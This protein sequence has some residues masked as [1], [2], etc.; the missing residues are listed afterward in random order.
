MQDVFSGIIDLKRD[1]GDPLHI[2]LSAQIKQA[3]LSGA[4]PAQSRIPSSRLLAAKL[5]ISRNTVMA[6]LEQLKAEGYLE[7]RPGAAI[8]V[9]GIARPDLQSAPGRREPVNFGHKFAQ[10]WDEPLRKFHPAPYSEPQPFQ[11]GIPDLSSFPHELWSKMLRRAARQPFQPAAGYAHMSGVARFRE[12]LCQHLI[13]LRGV[14]AEPEQIIVTSSARGALSLIASALLNPGEVAWIE[15]PG[16]RSAKAIFMAAGAELHPVP[17][18]AQGIDVRSVSAANAQRLRLIYTTPSHQYPTG[19]VMSLPRRLELLDLAARSGAY[20]LEDDYDSEFQYRGRPIAALQ[21]LDRTGCVLY[22]G[23]FAKS[24]LPALRVGFIIVPKVLAA[25]FEMIHRHTG[26]F[27]PPV[28]QL[29][30]AD[31]IESGHYRAHVRKMKSIYAARL[32]A[33]A[34]AITQISGG[35]LCVQVPDG[36]LQTVVTSRIAMDDAMLAVHLA[37]SGIQCQPLRDF[38][39]RLPMRGIMAY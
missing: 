38:H 26:Q 12:I 3:V 4:L 34:E 37:T 6:A 35:D 23:T 30:L 29:A 28:M 32:A 1:G 36:G 20:I 25:G 2:Q 7:T 19:A 17:V 31:F 8:Y 22:L 9:A 33:F 21:G 16:F 15:E 11:P 39:W 10:R 18:D 13:E 24:L 14:V 27:V 5:R